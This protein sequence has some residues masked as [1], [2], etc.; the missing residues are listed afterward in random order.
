[1]HLEGRNEVENRNGACVMEVASMGSR[2]KMRAKEGGKQEKES[3]LEGSE[4]ETYLQLVS[5][6]QS[7]SFLNSSGR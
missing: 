1:M 4:A 6:P 5:L 2:A 3:R 7:S